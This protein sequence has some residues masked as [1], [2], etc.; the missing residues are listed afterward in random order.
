MK[1]YEALM[2]MM[3]GFAAFDAAGK[4]AFADELERLAD[5]LAVFNARAKMSDDPAVKEFLATMNRQLV[6][7]STNLDVLY[8]NLRE[9]AREL[10]RIAE[11]EA[12][13]VDAGQLVA[14]RAA[15]RAQAGAGSAVQVSAC[16]R[17]ANARPRL[18]SPS[19]VLLCLPPNRMRSRATLTWRR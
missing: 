8:D 15:L 19:H 1:Q 9:Q 14:F 3:G 10:R 2:N 7:I 12:A 4:A 6:F 13:I 17:L 5:R 16:V 18:V 11:A